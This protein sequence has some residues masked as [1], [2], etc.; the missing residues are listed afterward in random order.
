LKDSEGKVTTGLL[1]AVSYYKDNRLLPTGFDKSTA[2]KEIA[3]IGDAAEDPNFN[4]RGSVVLY[5]VPVGNSA[6]PYSI[7]AELLYQPIGFRW[8]HNLKP[9]GSA[10]E[11][12]RFVDYFSGI[13]SSSAVTLAKTAA[14]AQ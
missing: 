4:D 7:Q 1:S 8:A 9:Y 13:A 2:A 5:S 14:S 12:K 6:G 11:P 10:T 3:V